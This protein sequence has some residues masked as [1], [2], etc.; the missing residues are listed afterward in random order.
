VQFFVGNRKS[1]T[2]LSATASQYGTAIGSLHS[3]TETVLVSSLAVRRLE[4]SFHLDSINRA[5]VSL[6]Y[7]SSKQQPEISLTSAGAI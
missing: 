6:L 1:L 7:N 3:L 5:K 2:A 4:R